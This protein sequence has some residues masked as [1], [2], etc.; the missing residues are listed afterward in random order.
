VGVRDKMHV[1]NLGVRE[2]GTF[3]TI[4]NTCLKM[5]LESDR[6]EGFSIGVV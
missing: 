4:L 6:G 1:E 5:L 3:T 2:R